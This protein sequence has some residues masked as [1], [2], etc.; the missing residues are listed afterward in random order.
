M[1]HVGDLIHELQLHRIAGGLLEIFME[2]R[3]SS[4]Q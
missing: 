4:V 2:H 1:L 3:K